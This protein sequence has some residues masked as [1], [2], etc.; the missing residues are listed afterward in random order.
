MDKTRMQVATSVSWRTITA[1][2]L[3]SAFKLFAGIFAGSAAM[4]SD[5]V[6]SISDL[7]G[8]VVVLV[9][10]RMANP[11]PDKDH[12]YGH[13]R[14]ECLAG[15]LVAAILFVAG[16]LIGWNG[17]QTI[18]AWNHHE[19]IAVPGVLALVAAAVSI[20]VKEGMYWYIRAHAKRIDSVALMA[21]AWHSR[22]DSLS[23]IGSFAGILG[24]RM[25]FPVLDSVASVVICLFILKVALDIFKNATKKM[26]DKACDDETIEQMRGIALSQK[27]VLGVDLIKT[28][29]F[30]DRIYVDMEISSDGEATLH[31]AH[32]AAQSVHDAI[33]AHFPKVK[34]CMIHVNPHSGGESED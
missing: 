26:T 27:D 14:I 20:A 28:R 17:L 7:F 25:G 33:E 19:V 30:G 13:E 8:D 23:S 2:I 6:H 4:V 12:P 31:E 16:G 21:S 5:A 29:V 22:S 32:A 9:S 34:H 1:N 11:E 3:L 18:I 24:A 10:V 15:I